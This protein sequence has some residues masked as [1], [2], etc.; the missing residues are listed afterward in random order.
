MIYK[1]KNITDSDI[2]LKLHH[3][4][5]PLERGQEIE[6]PA[7]IAMPLRRTEGL[8]VKE[9]GGEESLSLK[10]SRERIVS[11]LEIDY[12]KYSINMLRSIASDLGLK[13]YFIKK[14]DL[15]EFIKNNRE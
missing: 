4:V 2:I 3:S 11:Q 5:L 13:N 10:R 6:V 12:S 7:S 8:L 15:I 1:I 9:G 14:K